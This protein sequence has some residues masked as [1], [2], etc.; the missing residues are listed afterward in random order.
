[1]QMIRKTPLAVSGLALGLAGLGVL[2]KPMSE[3][4][5]LACG[6]LSLLLI[7]LLV[8]RLALDAQ[9]VVTE[10][11]TPVV[12]STLPALF[13]A[14]TL[15]TTYLVPFAKGAAVVLWWVILAA[16]VAIS[17]LF[18][19]RYLPK[20]ELKSVLPS[21]FLVFVGFVVSAV[22]SPAFDLQPVGQALFWAGLAG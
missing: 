22:T 21:W 6:A 20:L 13:M 3:V 10:A 7:L 18:A 1:M 8:A 9:A 11:M 5:W 17:V 4:A 15:L 19:V 16:Q 14:A 12:H 2:L